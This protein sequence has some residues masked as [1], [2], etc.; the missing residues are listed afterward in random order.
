MPAP[1]EAEGYRFSYDML[2]EAAF[3]AEDAERYFAS[4]R[5]GAEDAWRQ[6]DQGSDVF[7]RP[8]I[9]VKL[10]A[11]HPRYEVK[12]EARVHGGASA[13]RR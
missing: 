3:T 1:L 11:L 2:G 8:S 9:S 13:A 4:Y 10:S 12:Q 7:A 6:G 5:I